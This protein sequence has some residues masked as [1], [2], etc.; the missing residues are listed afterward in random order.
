MAESKRWVVTMS[1]DRPIND[2][3]SDIAAA[4]FAV[5]QIL[6]AIGIITGSATDTVA[7][8]VRA[9]PGVDDVSLDQPPDTVPPDSPTW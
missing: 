1:G 8:A 2:V 4:G 6:G 7:E 3:A 5:D 9:I